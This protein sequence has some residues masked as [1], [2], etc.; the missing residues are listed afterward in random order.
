MASWDKSLDTTEI[1]SLVAFLKGWDV[2]QEAGLLLTPPAPIRIDLNN[3]EE[4]LGLGERIFA[5]TCTSCHGENGSG[6]TGPAINSQQFLSRKTDEQ[7]RDA[8]TYGGRRPNSTMPAFGDRM[9]SVEIDALVEYIRSWEPTAPWVANPRGTEQGG[10][11]PPWL[12]ATPDPNN[13]VV[14][15]EG[16]G[17]GQGQGGGP[18]WRKS[19]GVGQPDTSPEV[20][21]Q[22]EDRSQAAPGQEPEA[23]MSLSFRG[24]VLSIQDNLLTFR[25]EDGITKDA[26]LGPPWFWSESGILLNPGD[27]IE[28]EGFESP[29]HMELNWIRNLTT[30]ESVQLRNAEGRP[31]WN[32]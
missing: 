3:A 25:T 22:G 15:G 19:S 21:G 30:G 6:G 1:S 18:S 29:D 28:L 27:R 4:V 23:G 17:Q 8:V 20:G 5:A 9:T 24:E 32:E 11:G 12:R 7:I 31:V 26:M 13:P 2:I 10:G 14:P 16:Q